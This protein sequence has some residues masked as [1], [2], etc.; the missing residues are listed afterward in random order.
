[1]QMASVSTAT[2]PV[3]TVQDLLPTNAPLA[4]LMLYRLRRLAVV[5]VLLDLSWQLLDL[6]NPATAVVS[7][8]I[9]LSPRVV[10]LVDQEQ[11]LVATPVEPATVLLLFSSLPT[12]PALRSATN[13][14][15]HAG[16]LLPP[17]ASA[18]SQELPSI[19]RQTPASVKLPLLS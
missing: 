19:P 17:I 14:A 12:S 16:D 10:F 9:L 18:V 2:L 8:A 4:G 7:V 3:P 11:Y 15:K 6:A 13:P 5:P 1:M